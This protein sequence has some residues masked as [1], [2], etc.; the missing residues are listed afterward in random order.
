MIEFCGGEFKADRD[1]YGWKLSHKYMGTSKDGTPK[2]YFRDTYHPSL[3]SVCVHVLDVK[4]GQCE[5]V[6]CLSDLFK[7]AQDLLTQ[8]AE[9][10]FIDNPADTGQTKTR[11]RY[12]PAQ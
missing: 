5:D 12:R 11:K 9:N 6:K 7:K 1:T 4:S 10:R 8:K 3:A 2:E